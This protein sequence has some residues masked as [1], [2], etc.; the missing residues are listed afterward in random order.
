MTTEKQIIANKTNSKKSTGAVTSEGKAIVASNAIKHGLLSGRLILK[1]ESPNEYGQLLD[2][3]IGSLQPH[4]TLELVLVEKIAISIWRQLRLIKA[5]NAS[6]E[7]SRR[8][9]RKDNRKSVGELMGYN[10]FDSDISLSDLIDLTDSDNMKIKRMEDAI[11]EYKVIP[12]SVLYQLDLNALK[13][14]DEYVDAITREDVKGLWNWANGLYSWCIKEMAAFKR[15][16][17]IRHVAEQL[18]LKQSAPIHNELLMRYQT[19]L[20]AELYKAIEAL[21]KQQEWRI[22]NGYLRSQ[23]A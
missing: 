22:K 13:T 18:K 8:I 9:E 12:D 2:D 15:Q 7:L 23:A 5:E 20:D 10:T 14:Q 16:G 17:E 11:G 19:C 4:G 3:L 6:I 1:D 21:R